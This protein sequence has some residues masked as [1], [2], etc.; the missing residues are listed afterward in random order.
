MFGSYPRELDE[1]VRSLDR[2]Y[3]A[4][5]YRDFRQWDV[6]PQHKITHIMVKW[7]SAHDTDELIRKLLKD[8]KHDVQHL[9]F[10]VVDYPRT[11]SGDMYLDSRKLH[12]EDLLDKPRGW[13]LST[14]MNEEEREDLCKH[15]SMCR[16]RF[17]V[18][19]KVMQ[20]G[21]DGPGGIWHVTY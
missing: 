17:T 11:P 5:T 18:D 7:H 13:D 8:D 10:V 21:Y 9:T 1:L 3:F 2:T 15:D 19:M 6:R 12:V 14:I 4:A 20:R 16:H